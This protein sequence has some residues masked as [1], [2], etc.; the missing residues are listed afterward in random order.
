MNTG[1]TSSKP[2]SVVPQR[3][4]RSKQTERL[5]LYAQLIL[6]DCVAIASGFEFSA[7]IFGDT[8][9]SPAGINIG[10]LII[11]I[12]V[13]QAINRDAYTINTLRSL[14]ESFRRTLG[15]FALAILV[16][17]MVG[18]FFKASSLLSRGA[19]L[20]GISFGIAF[21]GVGRLA[22]H[23]YVQ[24]RVGAHLTDELLILDGVA[25]STSATNHVIDAQAQGIR[26]DLQDPEMLSYLASCM[27]SYDRVVVA[28]P[29]ERQHAWALLLK[30]SNIVGEIVVEQANNVGAIGVG[31]L[32]DADTLVVS[33]GPLS[34]PERARKR[35]LDLAITVPALIALAVPFL[36][37]AIAIKLESKGPVFFKQ[38]RVGR[39][40]QLFNILKFRSMRAELCDSNGSRST[41]RDD[42]RIT[43]VGAF[44]RMTS[45]DELP[46]LINVLRGDMSL[47][48]P[49][50]HALGSLAGDQLFWEVT[51]R[52]WTRHALKPGIT[53]LAQIR[54]FRGNTVHRVDLENRLNSDLEYVNNWGLWRD[55]SILF[56]TLKVAVHKNAY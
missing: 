19:F 56:A 1:L 40:N 12:Y 5:L 36:F 47:V 24:K 2:D 52:Y 7:F 3:K 22:F 6:V 55:I 35:L 31:R 17:L 14:G 46:Q 37:I 11:G 9:L 33:R 29:P 16:V 26:P 49:R 53:G 28:C 13:I 45:I 25:A 8:Y 30:G 42:D 51:E 39:S 23:R 48:G 18:Y 21:L 32:G 54:G 44:I 10:L 50:P 20:C 27:N 34:V 15:A 4:N 43:R 41:Q 38:R